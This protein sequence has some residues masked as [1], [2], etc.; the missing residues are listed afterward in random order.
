MSIS[1]SD[2][3]FKFT[4]YGHYYVT[5]ISPKTNKKWSVKTN[6]MPLIDL[7]KNEDHP[8]KKDLILLKRICK[9]NLK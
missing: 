1:I 7:T 2:F 5:Y 8:K 3:D 4:G 9:G 6:D